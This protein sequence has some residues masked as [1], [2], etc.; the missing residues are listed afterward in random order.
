VTQS[1][2]D[3]G[4]RAQQLRQEPGVVP[5]A[6]REQRLDQAIELG[7]VLGQEPARAIEGAAER[8]AGLLLL[9][10]AEVSDLTDGVRGHVA[11]PT[12]LRELLTEQPVFE[13]MPV[14]RA[15]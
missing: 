9:L 8:I 2:R 6:I 11:D 4:R 5:S 3:G 12:L 10:L 13:I 14:C 1:L 7:S 15:G